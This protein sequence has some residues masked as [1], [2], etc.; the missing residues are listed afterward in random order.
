VDGIWWDI[1]PWP[2]RWQEDPPP[3]RNDHETS[4][5]QELQYRT[6]PSSTDPSNGRRVLHRGQLIAAGKML[7]P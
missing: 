4:G 6:P 5:A 2:A 3:P 1:G 7:R